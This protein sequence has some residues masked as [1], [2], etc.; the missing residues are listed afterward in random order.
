MSTLNIPPIASM[1]KNLSGNSGP[2][3]ELSLCLANV[4]QS[5]ECPECGRAGKAGK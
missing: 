2:C 4:K 1:L 3:A 5:A